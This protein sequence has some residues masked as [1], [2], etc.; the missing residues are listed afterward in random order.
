[1]RERA[2]LRKCAEYMQFND[3]LN[4]IRNKEER[5]QLRSLGERYSDMHQQSAASDAAS[6]AIARRKELFDDIM[7]RIHLRYRAI[8]RPLPSENEVKQMI[9]DYFKS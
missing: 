8:R 4:L 6:A 2:S 7:H 3:I 1:M 9:I 5:E